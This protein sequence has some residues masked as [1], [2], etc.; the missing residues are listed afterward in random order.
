MAVLKV[1]GLVAASQFEFLHR[2]DGSE[3][4]G[5]GVE[6]PA[7][8]FIALSQG[9]VTY[10]SSSGD[11]A[12]GAVLNA[13]LALRFHLMVEPLLIDARC[14]SMT[15]PPVIKSAL[16]RLQTDWGVTIEWGEREGYGE[17][18]VTMTNLLGSL[19]NQSPAGTRNLLGFPS[20]S[21]FGEAVAEWLRD[22][23]LLALY[24]QQQIIDRTD[25]AVVRSD[26]ARVGVDYP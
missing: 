17:C 1:S 2:S 13:A 21:A 7:A 24:L 14:P 12:C 22:H 15:V 25:Q 11:R 4:G 5:E 16:A 10:C 26:L 23:S 3:A 9:A 8:W 19:A 18:R 6:M 20:M